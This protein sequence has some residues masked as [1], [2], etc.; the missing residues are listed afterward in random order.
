[1]TT[2]R[3]LAAHCA[4]IVCT[5]LLLPAT[6]VHAATDARGCAIAIGGALKPDNGEVWLRVVE[7]AGGPGARFAV[8]ASASDN[9]ERS[10]ASII[11]SLEKF[12]AVAEHIP[13]AVKLKSPA[14]RDAVRDPALIAKVKASRGVY[15]SGGSQS[16]ITEVLLSEQGRD[17]LAAIRDVQKRGGVIAGSSAGAAIMS[18]TMFSEPQPVLDILKLGVRPGEDV[19]KGLGFAG[20]NLIVDQ[21]FLKRG[22]FGRLLPALL[23]TGLK[24][25]VGVDEDSAARFCGDEVEVFGATGALVI[26][27]SQATRDDR[28][29]EFNVKNARLS[30]LERGDRFNLQTRTITPSAEKLGDRRIDPNAA[31]FKPHFTHTLFQTDILG[32]SAVLSVM[33]HLIDGKQREVVGLAFDAVA[34]ND[35]GVPAAR[36]PAL[37]FEFRFSRTPESL[38]WFTSRLGGENYTITNIRVDVTPITLARPLYTPLRPGK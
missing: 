29:S 12:G 17:M 1:M 31:S 20:N 10:A 15:F 4:L 34:L 2:F 14:W 22:R 27:V 35:A 32:D 19:A 5:T 18:E 8:F 21:H 24:L 7:S 9:P 16:R 25:G 26:D 6:A 38:G 13:V 28:I 33:S 30:Y 11:K 3:T 36:K 23:H 37:G